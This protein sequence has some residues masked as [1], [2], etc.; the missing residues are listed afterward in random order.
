MTRLTVYRLLHIYVTWK[1]CFASPESP[2]GWNLTILGVCD[3]E[4]GGTIEDQFDGT[5][6]DPTSGSTKD[7]RTGTLDLQALDI[8]GPLAWEP[9]EENGAR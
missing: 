5:T 9:S 6:F 8:K 4:A 1:V 3:I 7:T 2:I